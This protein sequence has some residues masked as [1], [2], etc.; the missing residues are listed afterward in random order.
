MQPTHSLTAMSLLSALLLCATLP[1]ASSAAAAPAETA[2]S[3]AQT[4]DSLEIS[5]AKKK[6]PRVRV[7]RPYYGT[8]YYAAP[9]WWRAPAYHGSDPAFTAGRELRY[10][11]A[12]GQCM[13]D[14]GYGRFE[15]CHAN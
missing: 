5:A 1:G 14:L 2:G 3:L 11:R 4:A 10:R 9:Y 7:Y 8:P 15:S 13:I 12:I 6:R